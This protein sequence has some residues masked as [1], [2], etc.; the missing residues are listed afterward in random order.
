MN[1]RD[2]EY[3]IYINMYIALTV[4]EIRYVIVWVRSLA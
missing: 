1:L 4:R 3:S 2:T